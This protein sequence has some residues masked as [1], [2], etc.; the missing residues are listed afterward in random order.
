MLN[1]FRKIKNNS[2]YTYKGRTI[3]VENTTKDSIIYYDL[4]EWWKYQPII[5]KYY[6]MKK[7]DFIIN[8]KRYKFK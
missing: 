1:P 3:I 5:P 8:V 7:R 2:R 4:L 6:S